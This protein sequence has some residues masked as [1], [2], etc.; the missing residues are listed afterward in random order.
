MAWTFNP[1]TGTFDYYTSG[2]GVGPQGPAGASGARGGDGVDGADGMDGPP[3][4]PG[5][6]GASGTTG[7]AG[8][9]GAQGA[10]G[11]DGEDGLAG[12][13]GAPGA[14]GA[15]GAQ[16]SPGVTIIGLD[17]P[18]GEDGWSIPGVRGADGAT[19]AVGAPGTTVIGLDGQD[20]ED[21]QVIPGPTGVAGVRGADGV[22]TFVVLDGLDGEDGPSFP[23]QPGA[24]GQS[25]TG[26][27]GVTI[28]G[29]DGA[30]GEDP[31]PVPG[32]SGVQGPPGASGAL[33]P[34]IVG[35]DGLDADEPMMI[36]GTSG[37]QGPAGIAG[38]AGAT[39]VLEPDAPDEPMLIPG[40]AGAAGGGGTTYSTALDFGSGDF[41]KRFT[42]ANGAVSATSKIIGG[43]TRTDITDAA[44]IGLKYE[45]EVVTRG[46]GTF[47]IEVR[48]TSAEG[49]D[50]TEMYSVQTTEFQLYKD[51]L[52]N[53]LASGPN[54]WAQAFTASKSGKLRWADFLIC[55]NFGGIGLYN[56]TLYAVTGSVGTTAKPTGAAL[57]TSRQMMCD[58]APAGS[59]GTVPDM[60]NLSPLRFI[61]DSEFDIVAGSNYCIAVEFVSAVV[62]P[63]NS[64]IVAVISAS[65]LSHSGNYASLSGGAWTASATGDLWFQVGVTPSP[66]SPA[67][68]Y[69]VG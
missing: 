24:P 10:D 13:P 55:T 58:A 65:G 2:G 48:V 15:S 59:L 60:S 12:P 61:F 21:P 4:P 22:T 52:N 29:L 17:G 28:V 7:A 11:V 36:P 6:P 23:G 51:N 26:A 30:D 41:C 14:Q 66:E 62:A 63:G 19:G 53:F 46:A 56:A 35:L 32:P 57:A 34:A 64:L 69:M 68:Q 39:I 44:D 5:A 31:M 9:S 47:D 25:I 16:G 54:G 20:A 49:D 43:I 3:G 42:I 27:P 1:F 33:G 45:Y 38:I 67:F 40:P 8:P 18:E 50:L 37:P